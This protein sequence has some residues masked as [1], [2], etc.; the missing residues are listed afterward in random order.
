MQT[1]MI[2]TCC[3]SPLGPPGPPGPI[4]VKDITK[5]SCIIQWSAPDDDG[6]ADVFN[7]IVEKKEAGRVGWA[8]VTFKQ[9]KNTYRITNLVETCTYYFR[10]IGENKY[11][12]GEA[13]ETEEPICALDPVEPPEKPK[14]LTVEEVTPATVSLAWK[15]PD[16][17]GGSRISGY[18]V[19][20]LAPGEEEW[21]KAA[22]ARN[23]NYTV[24]RLDRDQTYRFRVTTLTEL[25]QSVPAELPE[26]ITCKEEQRE[27]QVRARS[28]EEA[29]LRRRGPH[30][31]LRDRGTRRVLGQVGQVSPGRSAEAGARHHRH[32]GS[33][34]VPV[35]GQGQ[36]QGRKHQRGPAPC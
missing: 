19:E 18:L 21:T 14:N 31:G 32:Q 27:L 1:L 26:P 9:Q 4:K 13:V 28:V 6:G 36:E 25:S 29:D 8:T 11:G 22:T 3:S 12:I 35:Q 17:D 23:V 34:E 15:R 10:V 2:L 7:Y 33:A 20:Y 24:F 5:D 30:H 16:W